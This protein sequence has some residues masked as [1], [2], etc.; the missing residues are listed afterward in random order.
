MSV[1]QIWFTFHPSCENLD[2][3]DSN[4]LQ[5]FFRFVLSW[6]R[7]S[8]IGSSDIQTFYYKHRDY[9]RSCPGR[10]LLPSSFFWTAVAAM[11]A[12]AV[13]DPSLQMKVSVAI[14]EVFRHRRILNISFWKGGSFKLDQKKKYQ[15]S[16]SLDLW[17][18]MNVKTSFIYDVMTPI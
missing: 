9:I 3:M 16:Y 10:V 13:V 15:K 8:Q 17:K 6:G 5:I 14:V 1:N 12:R 18:F 2:F 4:K 11:V 7:M